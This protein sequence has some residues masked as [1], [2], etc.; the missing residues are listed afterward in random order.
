M[1]II[2]YGSEFWKEVVNFDAL[3]RYGTISAED[4]KLFH[5]ADSPEDAM[6]KLRVTLTDHKGEEQEAEVPAI[7]HSTCPGESTAR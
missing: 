2:L 7:S 3:V 1:T 6:E 5:F 4:V